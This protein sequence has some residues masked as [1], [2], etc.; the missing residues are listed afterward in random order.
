MVGALLVLMFPGAASAA[1]FGPVSDGVWTPVLGQL[2]ARHKGQPR[3]V[4]PDAGSGF[5]LDRAELR[6]RVAAAPRQE[7]AA[8][9]LPE[10]SIP[11]PDGTLQ[12][13]RVV[14]SPIMSPALA[15]QS[16]DFA[17]YA[18]VG[19]DDPTATAR[20]DI[21]AIGFHA[22][23]RSSSGYWYVDPAYRYQVGQ[24]VAYYG[25][26]LTNDRPAFR[27]EEVPGESQAAPVAGRL[28][29]GP[30]LRTYRL[31]LASDYTY[32]H[33]FSPDA[34]TAADAN[35]KVN[36]AKAALMNR[37]N[38]IY[39]SELAIRMTLVGGDAL[40]FNTQAASDTA[41][42][43]TPTCGATNELA[44]IQTAVDGAVVPASYDIGHLVLGANGGGLAGLGVVGVNGSKAKGCTGITDPTGDAFAVDYVAH[45]MGHQFGGDH[46]FN[47]VTSNCGGGNRNGPTAV[48]PGSGSSIMAY[49]GICGADDLQ[50]HSDP[51]FSFVSFDEITTF[52]SGGSSGVQSPTGNTTPFVDAGANHT[53]PP[54][55]PFTLTGSGGDPDGAPVDYMW[56]ETDTG[57]AGALLTQPRDTGPLFRVFSKA[58]TVTNAHGTPATGLNIATAADVTRTFPDMAQIAA[59]DTNGGA[60]DCTTVDCFSELL[61]AGT[62]TGGMHFRLTVRDENPAGGGVANDSTTIGVSGTTPFRVTAPSAGSLTGG[63]PV[64]VAWDV[65]QTASTPIDT[66]QVRISYS[67]DGGLTFPTEVVAATANDGSETVTLPNVA[68][69]KGRF[70]VEGVGNVFFDISHGD[71]NV[72]PGAVVT[73]TVTTTPVDTATPTVTTTPVDTATPTVTTTPVST[74]TVTTTATVTATPTVTAAA[75]VTSSPTNTATPTATVTV[76]A[77]VFPRAPYAASLEAVRKR[78]RVRR[79]RIR[80]VV[81]CFVTAAA[82]PETPDCTGALVLRAK[83]K[84]R[85]RVIGRTAFTLPGGHAAIVKLKLTH[86]ARVRVQAGPLKARIVAAVGPLRT[87]RRVKL[88]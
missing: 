79:G 25:R 41:F 28:A 76:E 45:E 1:P 14:E 6:D 37:V 22:S 48:E 62:R 23:V 16:G 29:T 52:A 33:V 30:V 17:S 12:R 3:F 19:I 85:R 7:T 2:A 15:A 11:A 74:A 38:Q 61:P 21:S 53:I 26:D 66:P 73:P 60:T 39:T 86:R 20:F 82:L 71:L 59:G 69:T 42:G 80:P 56:E 31:A 35:T 40:N 87:A 13:F 58:A 83:V 10:I 63:T 55:T 8:G 9:A 67:T 81:A 72:T 18:G 44:K 77:T 43:A 27:E 49:A 5:A 51:Y 46:S 54:R 47:G 70:K 32:R 34:D 78:P 50:A 4:R 75:T 65:G 68:T 57:T 36:A 88:R 64:N 24:Y 84:G